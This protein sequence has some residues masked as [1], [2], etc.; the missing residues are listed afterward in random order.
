MEKM[1]CGMD[2]HKH[3]ITGCIMDKKGNVTRQH[4]FPS[5]K[6]SITS[7]LSNTS[8]AE[9]TI[10]LEACGMWRAIYT[11]LHHLGYTIKLADPR[12]VHD[13][14]GK[15]KTDKG[16]ATI[17]ADLLRTSYLPEV[18]IPPTDILKLRDT[19]R[20]K[21]NL[22]RLRVNIQLKIKAYLLQEGIHYNQ[23]IWRTQTLQTIAEKNQNL[24]NL[25][26]L[27]HCFK[28]E[29]KEVMKR[30]RNIAKN[31][32]LTNLLM[33]LP[34]IG[35]YSSLLIHAEIG[36][37]TRF[38][39]PRHLISYA[40]LCPGIYKSGDKERTTPNH[41]VNKWLKWIMYECSGRAIMLDHNFQA[42][43]HNIKHRKGFKT[44]RRATARKM[45]TI[46]WHMLTKEEPYKRSL[47]K[48]LGQT[49]GMGT[50]KF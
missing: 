14:A 11:L 34:G 8:N 35:D 30:I 1:Y 4:T 32:T 28:E 27:Y 37:I 21:A 39:S 18:Y 48:V 44:A 7:F 6:E 3:T 2:I 20:H 15:K 23:G 17:L 25:I 12:K 46:I 38:E 40:G 41:A 49:E 29:E 36:N 22:T 31:M 26:K 13:I 10:A 9:I 42:Y 16:D 43:Y 47:I 19:T 24:E 5:N 33:T 50:P 45:L